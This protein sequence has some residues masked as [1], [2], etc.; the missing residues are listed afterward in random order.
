MRATAPLG[1]LHHIT[2]IASDPGMT[3]AFW[4]DVLGLR[5]VKRTVNYDDPFTHHLYFGDA[6]G[7]P[8]T[9]VTVFPHPGAARGR[10]GAGLAEAIAFAIP[11]DSLRYWMDRLAAK[12]IATSPPA[13]RFGET[14]LALR[15]PDGLLV[16][17][18]TDE[19]AAAAPGFAGGE[20]PAGC[21]I[22]GLFGVTLRLADIVPTASVLTRVLGHEAGSVEGGR[23]RFVHPGAG[24]GRVVD[25]CAT[26][27]LGP[28]VPGAGTIHHVAFRA[29]DDAAQAAATARLAAMGLRVT[30]QQDRT[31]FRSTYVREP[32]GVLFE[33]ATDDPGFTVD[34]PAERLGEAL[35]L[36]ARH[37][38]HRAAIEAALPP[39]EPQ[40]AA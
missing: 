18:V 5:L 4:R 23:H 29:A 28:G 8:G 22:R 11:P 34:E 30:A 6:Q 24:P 14:V 12:A 36:P 26:P 33:I 13:T 16:E 7:R 39:L 19:A 25:L 15:D 20:V 21:A 37:E 32:G 3:L 1:R 35:M 10:H 2:A 40:Q 27:G 31:Y 9:V 38:R 17:L